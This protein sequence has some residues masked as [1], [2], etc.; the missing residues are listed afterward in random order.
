MKKKHPIIKLLNIILIIIL[1]ILLVL[2]ILIVD[3]SDNTPKYVDEVKDTEIGD[4]LGNKAEEE[5][6]DSGPLDD[7]EYLFNDF[8]IIKKL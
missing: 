5:L 8:R 6:K 2:G 7:F 3:F 1:S 4:Y